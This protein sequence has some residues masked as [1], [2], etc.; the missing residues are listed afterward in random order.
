MNSKI[1]VLLFDIDGTLTNPRQIMTSEMETFLHRI[2]KENIILAIVGGSDFNKAH[3]QIG[4]NIF[5][6]FKY[7]FSENGL[8]YYKD[9]QLV[10]KKSLRSYFTQQQLNKFIN[11]C[12]Y[13]I[14]QIDI[15]VKTGTFIE[16]RNGMLN[17]SPIGRAC[18][19]EEREQFEQLDNIHKYRQQLINQLKTEF[20]DM[21]L[22]YSIGGQI[23]FDVFPKGTDKSYCLDF[24]IKDIQEEFDK[25]SSIEI[26]FF[27]DKTDIGGN[28]H[29]IHIDPRVIGHH[30]NNYNDTIKICSEIIAKISSFKNI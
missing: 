28:D 15:P 20:P 18:S 29:E 1:I 21:N 11:R 5:S 19:K 12:L 7:V 8:V 6:L 25:N 17:I 14:S 4:E 23:S 2:K 27:G 30:V 13:L 3:E 10:H 9:S 24:L 16:Y 22:S 26:H